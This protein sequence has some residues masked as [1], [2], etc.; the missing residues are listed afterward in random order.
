MNAWPTGWREHTL[1]GAGIEINQFALDVLHLWE[2]A[3]PTDRW[4]NNPLGMPSHGYSAPRAMNS[5]YAAFPTMTAFYKAF[6]VAAH[7]KEGKPLHVMLSTS[8]KHSEAWRVIHS[9]KWPANDTETDYPA[10]L[11]DKLTA[12]A[13]AKLK[14]SPKSQ[15]KT[16]GVAP[17]VKSQHQQVH[18]QTTAVH[19]A[20]NHINDASRA[21]EYIVR[22]LGTHG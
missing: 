3:T 22:R 10:T 5:P 12:D 16:V 14:V 20:V 15:R 11:L 6:R 4:T 13:V 19:H 21:I 1:R 7:A 2:Q 18:A 17:D 8:D 9:L